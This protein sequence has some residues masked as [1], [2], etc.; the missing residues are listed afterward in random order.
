MLC[1]M[2]IAWGPILTSHRYLR[3]TSSSPQA[4][5][6][7]YIYR[8]IRHY[9]DSYLCYLSY[10]GA[11]DTL[12]SCPRTSSQV[13]CR[14]PSRKIPSRMVDD[15]SRNA[16]MCLQGY[17]TSNWN[18]S[19]RYFLRSRTGIE[20]HRFKLINDSSK[21]ETCRTISS[22]F[23]RRLYSSLTFINLLTLERSYN[24][25]KI[26]CLSSRAR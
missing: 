13:I 20:P 2:Y 22:G 24:V 23:A 9:P 19:R 3:V 17:R 6:T 21:N 16:N 15:L 7:R 14:Q 8:L 5:A 11:R 25:L 4:P 1:K 12:V 26:Q 10:T 18:T